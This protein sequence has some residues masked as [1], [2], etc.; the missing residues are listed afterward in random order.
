MGFYF[1]K[2][3]LLFVL[4]KSNQSKSKNAHAP[5]PPAHREYIVFHGGG[6]DSR[7]AAD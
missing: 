3:S 6:C 1:E 7:Q 4:L 2:L 5:T